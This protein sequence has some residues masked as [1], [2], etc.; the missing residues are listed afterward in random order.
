ML[1]PVTVETLKEDKG[2]GK[3]AKK[4]IKEYE[5][6]QKKQAKERNTM[7]GNQCKAVEK[8]AAKKKY[9]QFSRPTTIWHLL[10]L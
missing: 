7:S 3:A 8:L 2:Y 10:L 6:L 4:Q 1:V 9:L 5:T